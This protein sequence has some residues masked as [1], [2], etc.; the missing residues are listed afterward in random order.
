MLQIAIP[1]SPATE[2]WDSEKEEFLYVESPQKYVVDLEH[3]LVSLSKWESKWRKPFISNK[4]KTDE[5][6]IDYIRCMTLTSNVPSDAYNNITPSQMQDISAYINEPMTATW[7]SKNDKKGPNNNKVVTAE[8]IYHWMIELQIPADYD[9]WHLN[10]LIT[11]IEV[12]NRELSP[13]QKMST[14]DIMRQ[15][16]ALN[17]ARKKQFNTRG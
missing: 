14:K 6:A 8:I 11:L 2:A 4:E 1:A 15:N 13:N 10:R 17:A 12:R 3:S 5:E 16:A 7:F 9:K